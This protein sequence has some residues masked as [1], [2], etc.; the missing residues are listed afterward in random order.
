MIALV[1]LGVVLTAIAIHDCRNGRVPLAWLVLVPMLGLAV[2]PTRNPWIAAAIG[3][4]LVAAAIMAGLVARFFRPDA[5]PV[6]GFGAADLCLIG[7]AGSWMSE[8]AAA[9]PGLFLASCGA[10][11]LVW[12]RIWRRIGRPDW[13]GRGGKN[14]L[15]PALPP[16]C[17]SLMI[18]AAYQSFTVYTR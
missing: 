9:L 10:A 16:L 8:D 5:A 11:A 12:A 17:L 7:G 15:F 13:P 14:D 1:S 6:L 2:D 18:T 3:A 4:G